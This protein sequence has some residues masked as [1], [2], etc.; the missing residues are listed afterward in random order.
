LAKLAEE[1]KSNPYH[2]RSLNLSY[3]QLRNDEASDSFIELMSEY[4]KVTDILNHL[5]LSGMNF[6]GDQMREITEYICNSP[7]LLGVHLNDNGIARDKELMLEILDKFG[8][9]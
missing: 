2:I 3:N 7:N 5:D 1:F 8:L 6:N 9:D 4:L